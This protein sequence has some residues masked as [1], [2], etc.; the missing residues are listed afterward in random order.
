MLTA[1]A[2]N[3][4]LSLLRSGL[5]RRDDVWVSNH[6]GRRA[7]WGRLLLQRFAVAEQQAARD[8]PPQRL[9][10]ACEAFRMPTPRLAPLLTHQLIALT[11]RLVRLY[12]R[13]APQKPAGDHA[14]RNVVESMNPDDRAALEHAS[15][16]PQQQAQDRAAIVVCHSMP[17]NYAVPDPLYSAGERCPPDPKR[18]RGPRVPD[19]G[20]CLLAKCSVRAY[21]RPGKLSPAAGPGAGQTSLA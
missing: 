7:R 17:S 21:L 19:E 14:R 2:I 4:A 6:G 3:F 11:R 8:A 12:A 15:A 16:L 20:G 5:V 18:E 10:A 1:E 9:L 13:R